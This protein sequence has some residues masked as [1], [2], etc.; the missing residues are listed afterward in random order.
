MAQSI[1]K[2]HGGELSVTSEPGRGTTFTMTFP[3]AEVSA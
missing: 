3:I 2:R 1:V